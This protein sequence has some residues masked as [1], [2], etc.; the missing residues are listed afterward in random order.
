MTEIHKLKNGVT[1]LLTPDQNAKT[2]CVLVGVGI[3][4]NHEEKNEHGLA[5]FFEH[6]CFKGTTTYPDHR[7]LLIRMDESGLIGNAYTGR[8]Y[9]AYYLLGR[10]ERLPDMVENHL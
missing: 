5:H 10:A 9:T 1:V 8:E 6:M 2:V 7:H 3:G 4:A